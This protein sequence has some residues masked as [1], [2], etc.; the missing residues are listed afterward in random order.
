MNESQNFMKGN[1]LIVFLLLHHVVSV[2]E[3]LVDL[4]RL[5]QDAEREKNGRDLLAD[6]K[7]IALH[8]GFKVSNNPGSGNCMFHALSEQ[9]EIVKGVKVSHEKLRKKL[10]QF[11]EENSVLVSS[12][13]R[14]RP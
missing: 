4:Q 1:N 2:G 8:K 7:E 6:I 13:E 3:L 9:L 10:V 11:L 5:E 14:G 12:S